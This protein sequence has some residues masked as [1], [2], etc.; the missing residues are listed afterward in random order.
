MAK[1]KKGRSGVVFSTDPDFKYSYEEGQEDEAIEHPEQ[2]L[3]VYFEKK[4]RAGKTVTVVEGFTGPGSEMLLLSKELKNFCGSGGS[5]KD[6]L[7][8]IQGENVSKVKQF[9]EREGYGVK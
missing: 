7:I 3:H 4:G 5:V 6:R 2:N 1:N 8:L 9:L